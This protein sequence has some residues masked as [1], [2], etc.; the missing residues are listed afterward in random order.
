MDPPIVPAMACK[1][2]S[3][4]KTRVNGFIALAA[5]V[6]ACAMLLLRRLWCAGTI[7]SFET[8]L[9][10][11]EAEMDWVMKAFKKCGI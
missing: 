7:S 11:R 4:E 10:K 2:V 1:R 9:L 8:F 6:D 3:N 5:G